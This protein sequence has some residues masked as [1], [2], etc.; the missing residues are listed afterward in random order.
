MRPHKNLLSW[1]ESIVLVKDI[2]LLTSKFPDTEKFGLISQLRRASVSIPTNISEGG[3][4]NTKKEFIYFLYISCGSLSE[5]ETLLII[6]TDLNLISKTEFDKIEKQIDRISALL[7]GLI[8][9]LKS[10]S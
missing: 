3:A 6:A 7:Q 5:V 10:E 9:K 4:R 1:K 2:Y 8:R